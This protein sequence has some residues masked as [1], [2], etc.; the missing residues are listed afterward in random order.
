[1]PRSYIRRNQLQIR[2]GT[3]SGSLRFI[4]ATLLVIPPVFAADKAKD[5]ETLRNANLVLQDMVNGNTIS[6]TLLAQAKCVLI[7]PGVTL[8]AQEPRQLEKR[9]LVF[10][11]TL[12]YI[13]G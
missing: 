4:F 9:N 6:P 1:M 12:A 13:W 7:L 11:E 3:V 5:E 8:L 2:R 10:P